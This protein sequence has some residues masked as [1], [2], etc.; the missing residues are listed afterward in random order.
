VQIPRSDAAGGRGGTDTAMSSSKGKGKAVLSVG[1]D[2]GVS[3]DDDMPLQRRRW[4]LHSDGSL[5][6]GPPLSGE[7]VPEKVTVPQLDPMVTSST[8]TMTGGSGS[9]GSAKTVE[10]AVN[11]VAATTAK[12]AADVVDAK[13]VAVKE[14]T[15]AAAVKTVVEDVAVQKATADATA[16]EKSIDEAAT[17]RAAK[18]KTSKKATEE[19]AGFDSSPTPVMGAKRAAMPGHSTPPPM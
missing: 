5:V 12:K 3:S 8:T 7:W 11:A 6:S 14:T 9:S 10:E 18:A 16:V 19:L 1:S 13:E 2:D 17:R 4:L 15:D